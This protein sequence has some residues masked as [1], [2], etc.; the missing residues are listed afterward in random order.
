M[1]GMKKVLPAII[2]LW[3]AWTL[4]DVISDLKAGEYVVS[5]VKDSLPAEYVPT[6]VVLIS[7][8]LSFCTGTSWGVMVIIFP[9][10]NKKEIHLE[11][12]QERILF[13]RAS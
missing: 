10:G 4:G 13:P 8:F 11:P 5:N 2:V 1:K 6:I 9:L 3:F 7:G 12:R